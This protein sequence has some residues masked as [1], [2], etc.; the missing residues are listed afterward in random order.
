M[1]ILALAALILILYFLFP[2]LDGVILGTVFAYVGR[3]IRDKFGPGR[4]LG[5]LA[6][7]ICIVI[8]IFLILTLGML[9]IA[10]QIV[11][12]AH[13]QDAL[14]ATV[15][16]Q[17]TRMASTLPLAANDVLASSLDDALGIVATVASSIPLFHIG[18]VVSLGIIN[19]IISI[20][21]CYFLLADGENFVESV[22]N[23]LPRSDIQYCRKYV[24]HIDQILSGIYMGTIYTS[25]VGSIIAAFIFYGFE[26]GRAHV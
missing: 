24:I 18:R 11:T 7:C 12:L 23:L 4:R 20:P 3:P 26:I 2:F 9:E 21:V 17:T 15:L 25:I 22:I 14:R 16:I 19:F 10:N 1:L 6:A 13:N 5:S 8:P